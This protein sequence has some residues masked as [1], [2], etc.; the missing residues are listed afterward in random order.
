MRISWISD[1]GLRIETSQGLVL[2]NHGPK[3]LTKDTQKDENTIAI[4]QNEENKNIS[5]DNIIDS[6]DIIFEPGEYE[7]NSVPIQGQAVKLNTENLDES[8]TI[9][10]VISENLCICLVQDINKMTIPASVSE[11]IGKV[12][13]LAVICDPSS[14]NTV[15]SINSLVSSL[16]PQVLIPIENDSKG[17]SSEIYQKLVK[18]LGHQAEEPLGKANITKSG[19]QE[20]LKVLNLRKTSL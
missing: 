6:T 15:E 5:K 16:D 12:D 13:I 14:E 1:S 17:E 8:T 10:S 3:S 9:Y 18:E 20:T 7:I 19:L 11:A 2:Y 4:F